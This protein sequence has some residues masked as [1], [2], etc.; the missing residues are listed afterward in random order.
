MMTLADRLVIVIALVLIGSLY[1][2]F[3][4]SDQGQWLEVSVRGEVVARLDLRRDQDFRVLGVLGESLI[5]VRDGQA[6][7]VDSPCPG[8]LCIR[9]GHLHHAGETAA[10]LPNAVSLHV[11]GD[12][13][14]FDAVNF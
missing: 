4:S 1:F 9:S 12:N 8:K 10:C 3:W 5:Q 13:A 6:A 14:L 11:V 2:I 7:F